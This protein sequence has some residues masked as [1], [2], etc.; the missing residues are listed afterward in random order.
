M[1]FFH[2]HPR[3]RRTLLWGG[4]A[5]VLLAVL[6]GAQ[7]AADGTQVLRVELQAQVRCIRHV[8]PYVVARETAPE[9]GK[10]WLTV[11]SS[12]TEPVSGE[13]AL[14]Q[15]REH[16]PPYGAGCADNGNSRHQLV[17]I[18]KSRA[19][20]NRTASSICSGSTENET[21]CSLEPMRAVTMPASCIATISLVAAT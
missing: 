17:S 16:G 15:D 6:L 4:G 9:V 20:K 2:K 8:G 11:A 12:P 5:L 13:L 7:R 19:C 3:L 21:D 14:L 10:S 1:K 18:P